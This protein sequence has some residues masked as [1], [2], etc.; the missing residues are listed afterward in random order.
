MSGVTLLTLV[1]QRNP[2]LTKKEAHA[3]ILCGD[4]L[5]RG[6]TIKNPQ[7][8]VPEDSVISFR[9]ENYVSRGGDKLAAALRVFSVPVKNKIFIDA[10]AST[11]GFTHVL[12]ENGA[13][14]VY[15]VDV[16]YNQLAYSLRTDPRVSVHERT[17]ILHFQPS[18]PLPQAVVGDLSFRSI[19]GVVGKLLEQV[20]EHWAIF[21]CKPQFEWP[22][23]PADFTGVVADKKRESEIITRVCADLISEKAYVRAIYK[24][25]IRGTKGNREYFFLIEGD[26][27]PRSITALKNMDPKCTV[28][29]MVY[30]AVYED[31]GDSSE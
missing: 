1:R 6:E 7:M 26:N 20:K 5:C 13:S 14:Y 3:L 24:S 22:D 30:H 27:S 31:S 21:L 10:G 16:G 23:P 18:D 12:L 4:V 25:P 17:N 29:E 11:G 8:I 9:G 15:A 2:V 19:L 28:E